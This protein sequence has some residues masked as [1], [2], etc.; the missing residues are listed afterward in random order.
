MKR[1]SNIK[2][3]ELNMLTAIE[4]AAQHGEISIMRSWDKEKN[5]EVGILCINAMGKILPVAILCDPEELKNY[6][7]PGEIEDAGIVP[8]D[9]LNSSKK[10]TDDSKKSKM[11]DPPDPPKIIL[12]F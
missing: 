9:V 3:I 7:S 11:P 12:N 10:G 2:N 1:L 6:M 4:I 8:E 5:K